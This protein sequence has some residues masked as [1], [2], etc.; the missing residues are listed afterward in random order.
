MEYETGNIVAIPSILSSDG[1]FNVLT[2][3]QAGISTPPVFGIDQGYTQKITGIT[4]GGLPPYTYQWYEQPSGSNTFSQLGGATSNTYLFTSNQLNALGNY[5]FKFSLKDTRG[6]V[7]NA[8]TQI[9]VNPL[10]SFNSSATTSASN[11]I[12]GHNAIISS[13][14]PLNGTSPFTYGWYE[15]SPVSNSFA[16]VNAPNFLQFNNASANPTTSAGNF[17]FNSCVSYNSYIYCVLSTGS[18]FGQ[19]VNGNVLNWSNTTAYP[20]TGGRYTSCVANSGHIYCIGGLYASNGT[21]SNRTYYATLS[22]NGIGTWIQTTPYQQTNYGATCATNGNYIYCVAGV[23]NDY[24]NNFDFYAPISANGIGTW[25]NTTAYPQI[26]QANSC[27]IANG[28]IYCVGGSGYYFPNF[29]FTPLNYYAQVSSNGIGPWQNTTSLPAPLGFESCNISGNYIYCNSGLNLTGYSNQSFYAPISANG[30]GT[31]TEAG[32]YKAQLLGN[33]CT[34]SNGYIYCIGGCNGGATV[35]ALTWDY[36]CNQYSLPTFSE[37][38][39]PAQYT[40]NPNATNEAGTYSFYLKGTDVDNASVNSTPVTVTLASFPTF[41]NPQIIIPNTTI[42]VGQNE[43]VTANVIGGLLPYKSFAWKLNGNVLGQSAQSITLNGNLSDLGTDNIQVTV[44]DNASVQASAN[45]NLNVVTQIATPAITASNSVYVEPGQYEVF[46][47]TTS[48]GIPPYTYNF[49]VFNSITKSILANQTGTSNK[50]VWMVP[51]TAIGNTIS[52]NVTA[53]DSAIPSNS[54]NSINLQII[55]ISQLVATPPTVSKAIIDVGQSSTLNST[56]SG[57]SGSYSGLWLFTPYGQLKSGVVATISVASNP[58]QIAIS[59]DG[60][61]AYVTNI[62]SGNVSVINTASGS[63][64]KSIVTGGYPTG[65]AFSPSGKLAY[66]VNDGSST[67]SVIKVATNSVVKTINTGSY[68]NYIAINPQGTIAY[69]TNGAGD[70]ISV[71][72]LLQTVQQ[73]Q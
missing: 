46:T 22:A 5:G 40:F 73:T 48:G 26:V 47:A 56:I 19:T 12:L 11:I 36:Y 45:A 51:A 69:V 4:F 70:T 41:G 61:L 57:G 24:W 37:K 6:N 55:T 31:W 39:L 58:E 43:T 32:N 20:A 59:P 72:N 63:V 38:L 16:Q 62:Y 10:P 35:T 67:V 1:S 8:T 68:P 28:Y 30:I 42:Y 65:V 33:S 17:S 34:A 23:N 60:T 52:A 53:T 9:K 18:I 7:S 29:P 3:E 64:T 15:K 71:V 50:F 14:L 27:Q 66:V 13:G 21:I 2:V 54:S 44:T 49:L 25:K